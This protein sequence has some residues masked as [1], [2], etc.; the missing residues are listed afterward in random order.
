MW[1]LNRRPHRAL[2]PQACSQV[3]SATPATAPTRHEFH[4]MYMG[5]LSKKL[6]NKP[7]LMA[8]MTAAKIVVMPEFIVCPVCR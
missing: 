3:T 5:Q 1:L 4:S 2:M 8:V 6:K 7:R